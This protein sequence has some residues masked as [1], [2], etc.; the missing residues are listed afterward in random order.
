MAEKKLTSIDI[1]SYTVIST[2]INV[3]LSIQ[4]D[5]FIIP[6]LVNLDSLNWILM[7]NTLK[8]F[9]QEKQH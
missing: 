7:K 4:K 8:K 9:Q 6:Y 5:I 2:G 1:E 3:L